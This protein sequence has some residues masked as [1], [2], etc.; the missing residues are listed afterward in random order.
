MIRPCDFCVTYNIDNCL[1]QHVVMLISLCEEHV[2]G[3]FIQ[4]LLL[5]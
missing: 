2:I 1:R 3:N 5:P 4:L